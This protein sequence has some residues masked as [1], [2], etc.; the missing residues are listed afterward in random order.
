MNKDE[1]D[2]ESSESEID[3]ND[4]LAPQL[5]YIRMQKRLKR[6]RLIIG[7]LGCNFE[8]NWTVFNS[9]AYRNTKKN[10]T[11]PPKWIRYGTIYETIKE[12]WD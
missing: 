4:A 2:D 3:E 10:I 6:V 5:H 11:G 8:I 9:F 12:Y 7:N 1:F